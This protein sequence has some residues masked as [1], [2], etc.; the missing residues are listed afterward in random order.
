MADLNEIIRIQNYLRESARGHYQSIS[1]PP[2]T[3]FFHPSDDLEYFNYAI[4]DKPCGGDLREVLAALRAE[5]H[6][7]SRRA[8]FEFFEA[9]APQLPDS[10][11]EA[12][13]EE[14]DRQWSMLCTPASL[15]PAPVVPGLE[16]VALNPSSSSQDIRDFIIAQQEG[17][18]LSMK[19]DPTE[20]QIQHERQNL[21]RSF[22]FLGRFEGEPAGA[23]VFARPI[24]GVT[25]VAGIA[26]RE[27]F[28]RRGIAGALT[29]QAARTAFDMGVQTA[30]L[31][32]ADERAGSVYQRAGFTP[33]SI[34]L[35]YLDKN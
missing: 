12:G 14:E 27:A 35:A 3:L 28:R 5:F 20:E 15:Q 8:R 33:F 17:F 7:R 31:T 19:A 13:F 34:M 6:Q 9:F 18:T 29:V 21:N 22:A 30:C 11:C 26:T 1:L 25:E 23:A 2:F 32:A 10:L 16:V 4:P 24:S